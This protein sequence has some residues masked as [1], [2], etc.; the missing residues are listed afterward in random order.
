MGRSVTALK[1]IKAP[2][3]LDALMRPEFWISLVAA[4]QHGWLVTPTVR[5]RLP[6]LRLGGGLIILTRIAFAQRGS[7][8]RLLLPLML[9][10]HRLQ[11]CLDVIKF[12]GRH[13]I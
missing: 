10:H 13:Q 12:R 5:F 1:T 7:G 8:I 11:A 9:A 2:E 6:G 3:T 4:L